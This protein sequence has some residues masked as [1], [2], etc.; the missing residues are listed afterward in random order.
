M[1]SI[2]GC[3]GATPAIR[4]AN[5]RFL[6]RPL[7]RVDS[8]AADTQGAPRTQVVVGPCRAWPCAATRVSIS[9]SIGHEPVI[10]QHALTQ[11][12]QGFQTVSGFSQA[13]PRRATCVV[14]VTV[15]GPKLAVTDFRDWKL[16]YARLQRRTTSRSCRAARRKGAVG[17]LPTIPPAWMRAA[18]PGIPSCGPGPAWRWHRR[19]PSRDGRTPESRR[20]RNQSRCAYWR[21]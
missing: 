2:R 14:Q 21:M 17:R 5:R 12:S 9:V 15:V 13:S 6:P 8:H 1:A 18:I 3:G 20:H 11:N 10:I 7:D 4:R 16:R 19:Q